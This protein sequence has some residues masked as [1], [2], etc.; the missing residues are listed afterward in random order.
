MPPI[1]TRVIASQNAART[2]RLFVTTRIDATISIA[3]S[4]TNATSSQS[5]IRSRPH[6][7]RACTDQ[8]GEQGVRDESLPADL[9]DLVNPDAR[10]G[11]RDPDEHEA[12]EPDLH[13][14]VQLLGEHGDWDIADVQ[15]REH[16]PAPAP[17]VHRHDERGACDHPEPLEAEQEAESHPAVFRRPALD[18]LRLRLGDVEGDAL[19]LR[20][21]CDCE[22]EEAEDLGSE[23]VPG[24]DREEPEVDEGPLLLLDD[25]EQVERARREDE[26][27]RAEDH[28]DFV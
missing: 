10:H 13:E 25:V 16:G 2:R 15:R 17:E 26:G 21:H 24:G 20:D 7:A 19:H 3:L 11:P 8:E 22:D 12:E 23:C 1:V 14:E 4:A 5:T 27:D 18:E 6:D 9:K 28:R